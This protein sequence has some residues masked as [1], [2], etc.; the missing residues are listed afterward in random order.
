M[1][2]TNLIIFVPSTVIYLI[3][4]YKQ[5]GPCEGLVAAVSTAPLRGVICPPYFYVICFV[6]R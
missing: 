4:N 6:K 1:L 2:T 3:R 5:G